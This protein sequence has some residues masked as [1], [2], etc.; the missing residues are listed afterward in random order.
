MNG[1]PS[2]VVRVADLYLDADVDDVFVGP[3]D[4]RG[5]STR[6]TT[7]HNATDAEQLLLATDRRWLLVTHDKRDYVLLAQLWRALADRWGATE[8]HAA[9]IIVPQRR[10]M[11]YP[12]S[13][14]EIDALLKVDPNLWNQV[15]R[16][17]TKWGWT[18]ES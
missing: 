6:T 14:D 9:V 16:F 2:S 1:I 4:A 12:R 18:L 17:D 7:R 13:A 11:P 10:V 15:V 5:H 3:L 8:Q